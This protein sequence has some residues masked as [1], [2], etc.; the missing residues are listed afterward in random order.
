MRTVFLGSPPF[1]T[2]V[3]EALCASR[4]RPS[5]L[6]TRPDRPRGRGRGVERSP[7]S[8]RADELGVQVLQ[9]LLGLGTL[10]LLAR[11]VRRDFGEP[12]ALAAA[13]LFTLSGPV[14][15]TE[16]QV[17]TETLLLF[18]CAA[19]LYLWPA[20]ARGRWAGLAFGV[21]AH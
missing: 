4:H 5:A 3:F 10:W 8:R 14:L 6:L 21:R 16:S 20:R 1:A 7:L 11:A 9:S 13:L 19:A 15:A 12:A 18:L 2:P 17:L